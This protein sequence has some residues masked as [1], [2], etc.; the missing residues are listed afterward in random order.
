MIN[1]HV[2]LAQQRR[3]NS[4]P[5]VCSAR[6]QVNLADLV[7]HNRSPQEPNRYRWLAQAMKSG[8][9]QSDDTAGRSARMPTR[10]QPF[11]DRVFPFGE[12]TTC[13]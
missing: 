11:D 8:S 10:D 2:A 7:G 12:I 9:V 5:T 3:L 6:T 1:H 13:S 4:P